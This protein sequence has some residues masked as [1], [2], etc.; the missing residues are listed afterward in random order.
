MSEVYQ[1]GT[2]PPR[3]SFRVVSRRS[4]E[5]TEHAV[6]DSGKPRRLAQGLET[7]VSLVCDLSGRVNT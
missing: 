2:S 4:A 6:S 5:F 1:V 3:L 7:V